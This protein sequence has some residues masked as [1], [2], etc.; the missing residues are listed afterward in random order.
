[1][2]MIRPSNFRALLAL[3]GLTLG[4][5]A[6]SPQ[7]PVPPV[8]TPR[9]SQMSLMPQGQAPRSGPMAGHDMSGMRGMNMEQMMAHCA[10][11]RQ[12]MQSGSPVN[13]H[14]EMMMAHCD[15]MNPQTGTTPGGGA[16][17]RH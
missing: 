2:R 4:A 14:T 9:A 3:T 16:Q 12:Q 17:H 8:T 6:C 11:M 7:Q 15:Q 13:P 5:A 10:E 1:M